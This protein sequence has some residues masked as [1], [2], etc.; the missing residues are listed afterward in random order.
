MN[1][2]EI[3]REFAS[4]SLRHT[5]KGKKKKKKTKVNIQTAIPKCFGMALENP[6]AQ[7]MWLVGH[8]VFSAQITFAYKGGC[9]TEE[10]RSCGDH[11]GCFTCACFSSWASA[12][13]WRKDPRHRVSMGGQITSRAKGRNMGLR[14]V[15]HGKGLGKKRKCVQAKAVLNSCLLKMLSYFASARCNLYL[16]APVCCCYLRDANET[17]QDNGLLLQQKCQCK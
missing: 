3:W 7:C 10:R 4:F 13:V 15:R 1:G 14:L 16:T 17:E 12:C 5:S 2:C 11:L 8:Q 9:A 6:K